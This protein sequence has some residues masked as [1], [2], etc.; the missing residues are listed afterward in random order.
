MTPLSALTGL[1]SNKLFRERWLKAQTLAFKPVKAM[2]ARD[3]LLTYPNPNE[4]FDIKTDA[5][6][7][8]L[9]AVIKQHGHPAAFFSRKLTG[10]QRNYTTIQKELLS[11][12]EKLTVFRPILLGSQIHIWTDH[13]NLT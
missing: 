9:G 8:Q 11:I 5:S 3:V 1:K 13:A 10:A 4:P 7:Y 6:D 12:V 2:I